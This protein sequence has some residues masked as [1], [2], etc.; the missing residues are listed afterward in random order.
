MV[1]IQHLRRFRFVFALAA[2][3]GV[4]VLAAVVTKGGS[5]QAAAPTPETSVIILSGDGMGAQQRTAIQYAQY[6]LDKRQ[7]MD[8]LPY[9]G[10]LDTIPAGPVAVTDSIRGVSSVRLGFSFEKTL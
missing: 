10:L 3:A 4:L 8:A 7:P 2:L 6:G 1:A 9:A 5:S